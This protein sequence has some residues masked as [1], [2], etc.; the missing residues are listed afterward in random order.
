V[1]APAGFRILSAIDQTAAKLGVDLVITSACDGAHSGPDDPH[2][3]GEAYDVRSHD[4]TAD[5][6]EKILA[7]VMNVLGWTY[8]FGFLEAAGT[9]NEH[10]H[11]QRKKGTVYPDP[12]ASSASGVGGGS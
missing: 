2:H 4:F 11:F 9:D 1:I 3:H 12:T 7:T 8:F 10:F 6:K 5:Q